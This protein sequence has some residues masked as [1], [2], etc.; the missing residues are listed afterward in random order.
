MSRRWTPSRSCCWELLEEL[1]AADT[2]LR[3]SSLGGPG[4]RAEYGGRLQAHLRA[5]AGQLAEEVRGR[6]ELNPLR[7]FDSK[8]RAP[9]R[10]CRVRPACSSTEKKDSEHFGE[11]RALLEEAGVG[12]EIDPTLVRGL[13]Y[14]TRTVFE[15]TSPK[16]GAQSGVGG[17]GRYDGLVAELG[18]PP[19]PGIGWAAGIERIMLAG[20]APAAGMAAIDLYVAF[21]RER[22]EED[23][24][25]GGGGGVRAGAGGPAATA[26]PV[27]GSGARRVAR[28][29]RGLAAER[30][31]GSFTRRAGRAS[32][33]RWSSRAVAK[34]Q[35]AHAERL[36]AR[37]LAIVGAPEEGGEGETG[38]RT[39][40]PARGRGPHGDSGAHGSAGPARPL[41]HAATSKPKLGLN[42]RRANAEVGGDGPDF[43]PLSDRSG[44]GA[45]TS[46]DGARTAFMLL[47]RLST[48]PTASSSPPSA[49]SPA[50]NATAR[51]SA[52]SPG[53]A[54][55]AAGSGHVYHGPVPGLEGLTRD[56]KRAPRSRRQGR[57]GRRLSGRARGAN[58][59]L[60]RLRRGRPQHSDTRSRTPL[61]DAPSRARH[62]GHTP[63]F[64]AGGRAPH[65]L[66]HL[67]AGAA[68]S[69]T[70]TTT[71]HTQ[72]THRVR[73]ASPS[74][75]AIELDTHHA[76]GRR[77]GAEAGQGRPRALLEPPLL[78]RHRRGGAGEGGGPHARPPRRG[79]HRV[80]LAGQLLRV[81]NP[82]NPGLPDPHAV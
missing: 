29:A 40:R 31:S 47:H 38:L 33:R 44:R 42:S 1:G 3:L 34:N 2:R 61:H 14:Y 58:P 48:E 5:N 4:A 23:P 60:D 78:R 75:C 32:Q 76:G 71:V 81:D 59:Q 72:T 57:T 20:R 8:T 66:A 74:R 19:T 39:P 7:A 45:R 56:V 63:H 16:L 77:L 46:D 43:S 53:G 12:Y 18:G 55:A 79:A 24:R 17:G 70:R 26:A 11:V 10:R 62:D 27:P 50:A 65:D 28:P 9:V 22:Q 52:G 41:E 68:S 67:P 25:K 36:G 69:A 35:R 6:I 15:L 82:R 37:Y 51:S 64:D 73:H 54:A 80:R 13:D 30:R 49:A 21:E